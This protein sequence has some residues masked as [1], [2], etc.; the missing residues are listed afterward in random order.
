MSNFEVERSILI[1]IPV[2]QV[3][4]TVRDFKTWPAWSP[5]LCAEPDCALEFAPDGNHYS[6]RGDIVGSGEMRVTG[7]RENEFIEY[8]V[9]F[10]SPWKSTAKVR[11]VFGRE[12]D[13]TRT[14]WLMNGKLPFYMFLFKG[15]MTA[16][17]G[18]DYKRGLAML[19]DLMQK[20]E[21]PS[22]LEFLGQSAFPGFSYVGVKTTCRIADM[23]EK[24]EA[25]MHRMI[26]WAQDQ[27]ITPCG[28]A[29]SIY[30]KWSVTQGTTTY[31]LGL[32]VEKIPGWL[33]ED[34][35][36]G[37]IPACEVERIRHTGSYLHLGNA[38]SAGMARIR[39]KVWKCS[40]GIHP[41][42]IYENDPSEV[43]E[44]ELVTMVYFPKRN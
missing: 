30:H 13:R 9:T 22:K 37:K 15:M 24:M 10:H 8:D 34:L 40:R 21:V 11:F 31:T 29:L 4:A 25:D 6:W 44:K 2:E 14:T 41:F 36:S 23:S 32:P 3:Y 39:A 12:G 19:K 42:E 1:G 5:W 27:H 43:S 38:W 33:P 17:I 16:A 26:K 35:V 28:K 7:E 18:L 20:G